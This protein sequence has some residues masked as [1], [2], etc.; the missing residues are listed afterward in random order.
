MADCRAKLVQPLLSADRGHPPGTKTSRI[1]IPVPRV[2]RARQ[3]ADGRRG[4]VTQRQNRELE[5]A[6]NQR[7]RERPENR[8]WILK[9][10]VA[11]AYLSFTLDA[12]ER[13][14]RREGSRELCTG[15]R[16]LLK[17]LTTKY[18][19]ENTAKSQEE[20][21]IVCSFSDLLEDSCCCL[22]DAA[23]LKTPQKNVQR[24]ART[25]LFPS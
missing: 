5:K 11:L 23:R 9:N 10:H 4:G 16:T 3:L 20:R 1:T 2:P 7:E 15:W 17:Q 21:T 18:A 22:A 24:A 14:D 19:N 13:E 12:P 6:L 25:P 8:R